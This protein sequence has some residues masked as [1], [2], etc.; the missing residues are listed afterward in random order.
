MHRRIIIALG[1]LG[2]VPSAFAADEVHKRDEKGVFSLV[3]EN[4]Y[5]ANSDR[6]YT[7]GIR[8]GWASAEDSM[9]EWAHGMADYLPFPQNG[10][11][12][13]A[14][15]VGQSMFAPQNLSRRDLVIGD[16]PYAGWLYGS[17]GIITDTDKTLD[18][19]TLTLGV[20]GPMSLA[21]D[22]QKFVH[23]F[24]NGNQP[25][26]WDHQLKNEAGFVLSYER[27]WRAIAEF[28]PF[29]IGADV[30]P[31]VGINL[32]TV[33]TD[34]STGAT[35]RLG[36]DLPADYGPPRIRPSLAG[37]DFFIP[38][39]ELN[40]YLFVTV[41]GRAVLRNIFLDG[42]TFASSPHVDKKLLVGSLQIGEAITYGET[43]LSYTHVFMTKEYTTQKHPSAFG[44]ITLSHRF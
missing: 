29:G 42:N 17:F 34:V 14:V 39:R 22:A 25:E 36:Y 40:G 10:R 16:H 1:L 2:L 35:I 20:V 15:T 41:A 19:L 32:G 31:H 38:S 44:V 18:N 5:F 8:F 27:K 30:I 43:R 26:G 6:D 13:L 3:F 33:N 37:S 7:N 9:P 4:D 23:R 21:E 11:Q 28:S 12:R 24:T